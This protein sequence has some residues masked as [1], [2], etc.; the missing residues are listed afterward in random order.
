MNKAGRTLLVLSAVAALA[1]AASPGDVARLRDASTLRGRL[2]GVAGDTLS[3]RTSFGPVRLHR[4]QVVSIVFDDSAAAAQTATFPTT[5]PAG[6]GTIEVVFKDRELSSKIAIEKKKRWDE[7]VAANRIVVEFL[8]DGQ[9][10]HAAV[11]S[12]TDKRIY[13]GHITELKNEIELRDFSVRVPVGLRHAKL[14]VRNADP[15]TFRDDFNPEPLN[16]VLAFENLD[17]R[18][19]EIARLDVGISRGKFR[20]G[21]PRLYRAE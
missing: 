5:P 17:I 11:D 12:T 8:V 10:V 16:L 9:V 15:D 7:H 2:V 1:P 13:K 3:F 21:R 20:T 19:G 4:S 14:I 18:A 6:A